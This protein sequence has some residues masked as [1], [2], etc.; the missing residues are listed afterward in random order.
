MHEVDIAGI[1]VS[2]S[3]DVYADM[4]DILWEHEHQIP[5]SL[6]SYLI[7]VIAMEFSGKEITPYT[8]D[9]I[10]SFV[11]VI[12]Q[13]E[14]AQGCLYWRQIEDYYQLVFRRY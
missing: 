9:I 14:E 6:H 3:I 4:F 12:L 1:P 11:A 8:A 13:T 10:A 5:L 2:Y 7:Q